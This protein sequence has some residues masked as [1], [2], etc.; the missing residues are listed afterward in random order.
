MLL[1][2]IFFVVS[3]YLH[4]GCVDFQMVVRDRENRDKENGNDAKKKYKR[5][6]KERNMRY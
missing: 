1:G 2:W 5:T 4:F 6:K 3:E